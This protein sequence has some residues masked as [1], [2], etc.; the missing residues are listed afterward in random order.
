MQRALP[1]I[2]LTK[3]G[4]QWLNNEMGTVEQPFLNVCKGHLQID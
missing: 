4:I 1:F 3:E 2:S